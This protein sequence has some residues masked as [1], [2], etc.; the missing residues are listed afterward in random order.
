MGSTSSKQIPRNASSQA[1]ED[2]LATL[3]GFDIVIVVDDS[4]SMQGSRWKKAGRALA[5]L[6]AVAAEYDSD[7]IGIQ[8]LN[9]SESRG[10][11]TDTET[12]KALFASVAPSG[13]TPLGWKLGKILDAYFEELDHDPR[14]KPANYIVITD[15]APTDGETTEHVI[16]EAARKLDERHARVAQIGIQF[17]QI[18]S[19]EAAT[20][21]LRS[22]DDDLS[23]RNV[24]DIVDTTT[25]E[26]H[27][28]DLVKIL[29]GAIN[30]RVDEGVASQ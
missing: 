12:V 15:G 11:V 9:S 18:G 14:T 3:K 30:R 21:Y 8:F 28:L 17:V 7:G 25:G 4:G 6:A 1:E 13:P 23:R 5:Q 29:I 26:G 22:L 27:H 19:D 24:R 16:V 20:S 2:A 10:N